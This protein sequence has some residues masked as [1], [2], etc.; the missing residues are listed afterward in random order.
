MT[1]YRVRTS[2]SPNGFHQVTGSGGYTSS[3]VLPAAEQVMTYDEE[4][5]N[6]HK[7]RD[8]GEVFN[9]PYSSTKITF[10]GVGRYYGVTTQSNGDNHTYESNRSLFTRYSAPSYDGVAI[11]ENSARQACRTNALGRIN[12]TEVDTGAFLG[13]L[14]KTKSLHRDLCQSIVRMFLS[15]RKIVKKYDHKIRIP[16]YDLSGRPLLNSRGQPRYKWGHKERQVDLS[17]NGDRYQN[18]SD[19]WLIIRMGVLPL[20]SELEGALRTLLST[21]HVRN[22]ASDRQVITKQATVNFSEAGLNGHIWVVE[23]K[24]TRV[25]TLGNGILYDTTPLG[26]LAGQLG[27]TRP[28]S[29][30][31]ELVPWSFLVDWLF[32]VGS[33]LDAIQPSGAHR[34]LASWESYHD[35]LTITRSIG[36]SVSFGSGADVA[37]ASWIESCSYT[38]TVSNRA[39]WDTSLPLSLVPGT[40][41]SLF[42][43][44]DVVALMLQRIR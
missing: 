11:D 18:M 10:E 40:G 29:S 3:F 4:I 31:W 7:R 9:N 30:I 20:I 16:L 39:L 34:K 33:W 24:M 14:S 28:L 38:K 12:K 37:Q 22:R 23:Q 35:V 6:F 21:R 32:K 1:R 19:L 17:P 42:R 8:A 15:D 27:L 2:P 44:V 5:P 41:L 13:E 43:S 25:Y 36:D 26:M